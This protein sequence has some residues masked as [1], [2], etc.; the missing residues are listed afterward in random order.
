M[1]DCVSHQFD[2]DS[3]IRIEFYFLNIDNV[4]PGWSNV[5]VGWFEKEEYLFVELVTG[6]A[7]AAHFI[8]GHESIWMPVWSN[9][10]KSLCGPWFQWLK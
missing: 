6:G 8:V 9:F 3:H 10:Y 2:G 7:M 1:F 4:N 5:I